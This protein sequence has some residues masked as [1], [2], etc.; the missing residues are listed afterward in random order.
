[1]PSPEENE[2]TR[3]EAADPSTSPRRLAALALHP[4]QL[5]QRMVAGN[6]SASRELVLALLATYPAEAS[7]NA[8]LPLWLIE[9]PDLLQQHPKALEALL[10]VEPP[11]WLVAT[12]QGQWSEGGAGRL[13]VLL[14]KWLARRRDT[15]S[16]LLGR[17]CAYGHAGTRALAARHPQS[18]R[19][20][21]ALLQAVGSDARLR[22][23]V[24]RR[25]PAPRERLVAAAR[26]GVWGAQLVAS[27]PDAPDDLLI[28]LASRQEPAV[29]EALARRAL[30]AEARA[31]LAL[32][33]ERPAR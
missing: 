12:L 17:L 8:A 5:T 30:P 13:D 4:D 2:Y 19:A 24:R 28:E 25:S 6:P 1:M 32:R 31:R 3:E 11:S 26:L 23:P 33:G 16:W 29:A 22:A 27:H 20:V 9:R 15:P 7:H 10:T 18:P 21:L 14:G